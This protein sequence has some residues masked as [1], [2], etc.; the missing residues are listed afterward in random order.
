MDKKEFLNS[1]SADER[2]AL[3]AEMQQQEK[4]EKQN[5]RDAYEGLRS[6]FMIDVWRLLQ[7]LVADVKAF[8]DHPD[9]NRLLAE[10]FQEY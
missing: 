7:P 3:I 2:K 6:Q 8:R 4:E 5:R 10:F 9:R 1:L